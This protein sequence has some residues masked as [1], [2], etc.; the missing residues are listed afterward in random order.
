MSKALLIIMDLR[1]E[2]LEAGF[3]SPHDGIGLQAKAG[4]PGRDVKAIKINIIVGYFNSQFFTISSLQ[5]HSYV[6]MLK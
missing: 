1:K 5:F 6:L 3:S 2:R 4:M